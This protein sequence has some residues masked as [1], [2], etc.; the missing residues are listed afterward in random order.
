MH[1]YIFHDVVQV[2]DS[3]ASIKIYICILPPFHI[4][5]ECLSLSHAEQQPWELYGMS[6]FI[7]KPASIAKVRH[8]FVQLDAIRKTQQT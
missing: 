3:T 1:S 5:P 2:A 6:L 8:A 4:R 7:E